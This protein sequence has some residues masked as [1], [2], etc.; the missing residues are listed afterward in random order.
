MARKTVSRKRKAGESKDQQQQVAW[1]QSASKRTRVSSSSR[2]AQQWWRSQCS[3]VCA[4][5]GREFR[6]QQQHE[7]RLQRSLRGFAAGRLP[8]ILKEREF[9][10]GRLNKVFASQWLNH[11]QVVCG[12]KC[13]TLFVADVLTGQITRIPM[14]KDR[15]GGG[16][17]PGGVAGTIGAPFLPGSG[18]VSGLDQQGCGIHAIELNPSGTLL[19]TGGDNPNSL[20]VY[21]L[22]TLDPVCVGDDGHKDWIFSIAWIS[23]RMAVSGSRDGSMGLWEVSEVVLSHSMRQQDEEGVPCY[24]HISHRALEDIPKEY[25]NPYNCKVRA[26]A[27]NNNHKELGA[28]SLDGYFHLWKAEQNLSKLLSTKLPHCKENVCLAYGQDWSVY[29]VGS[30]AHVSFLDPRQPTHN[31]KSVSSRE[32]GSGIRSVSFYE[33]IVTVGTG[34][35]SLLFYDIRAQRT[36]PAWPAAPRRGHPQTH[37]REGWLNHDETWRSYFSDINSFPNAVYTHCYDD[38]GT[39]LFV[40][41]GPLCSGL[42]GNYAAL[43]S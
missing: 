7:W 41:G 31:I 25:T 17:A 37:H 18:S 33:H 19:A 27:F 30:Q 11:R 16:G 1:C 43:W 29:A 22:P 40:A 34:Q 39:K 9:S 8:G 2:H 38:S 10:L 42:H 20:A 13:N 12:T 36:L 5:R 21:R 23:D 6:P 26:L 15:H 28:V 14:L 35:G 24:S 3:V 4:L 32:R